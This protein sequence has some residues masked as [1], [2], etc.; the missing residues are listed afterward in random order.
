[1]VTVLIEV[2]RVVRNIQEITYSGKTLFGISFQVFQEHDED[3][4]SWY[5]FKESSE[6]LSI[7]TSRNIAEPPVIIKAAMNP[8]SFAV[9]GPLQWQVLSTLVYFMPIM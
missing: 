5:Y 6:L 1:M 2:D 9:K 4:I 8:L 7:T 3:S